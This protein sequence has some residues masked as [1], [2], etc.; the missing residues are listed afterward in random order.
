MGL[1]VYNTRTRRLEPFVS[2]QPGLVKMYVCGVTVY[3]YCHLGHARSYVVWDVVRRYL[4]YLGYTVEHVQ[5]ITDID[6]K[7]LKRSQAE[8]VPLQVITERYIQASQEDFARL[9]ILPAKASPRATETI[10]EIIQMIQR[11]E[12]LGYA[13][14]SGGDVYYAVERFPRYGTLSGRSLDQMQAGASGRVD[15]EMAHKRHP[16]DFALWKAAKPG[17]PA[18]DSPWGPGRPGWHIECSAMIYKTLGPSIDIHTGG[19]DLIFPHH[20][21]EIAQSE[22]LTQ[23]PLARYWLH[24]GFVTVAGEKMSKSLGNFRTIRDVLQEYEPM[25]LRLWILQSH[26]RQPIEATPQALQAAQSGWHTLQR[27]LW[28]GDWQDPATLAPTDLDP[29]VQQEFTTAMNADFNTPAAV[30]VLFK[31]AKQL[32]HLAHLGNGHRQTPEF[33]RLWRTLGY[34]GQQVLGLK[35]DP[36]PPALDISQEIAALIARRQEARR[37]KNYAEADRIRELLAAQGIR[38]VDKPGGITEW[39]RE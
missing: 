1:T 20:E 12:S 24:N 33:Q 21:N 6:D 17:E 23:K 36:P 19:S 29:Q 7:I 18:W 2:Q 27:T 11:L 16:L 38:L 39:Y 13:Y 35:F 10:P 14:A 37:Q 9:N 28:F 22:P 30:A 34:L 31:V 8:G 25:A 32:K 15:E 5:N 26:Y 4:E 3:D